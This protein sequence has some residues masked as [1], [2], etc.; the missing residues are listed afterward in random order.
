MVRERCLFSQ[1][2][3]FVEYFPHHIDICFFQVNL[4]SSTHTDKGVRISIPN[5]KPPS[6]R[7]SIGFSQIAFPI[8]SDNTDSVHEKRLG[9]P[10]W[11]MM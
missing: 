10:C 11:T 7:A 9:F 2:N 5:W 1:V 6:N 4:M 3:F 8:K